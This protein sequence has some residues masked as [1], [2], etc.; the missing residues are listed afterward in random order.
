M[1]ERQTKKQHGN[2]DESI[3]K[4]CKQLKNKGTNEYFYWNK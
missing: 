2:N 4:S 3:V 1:Q